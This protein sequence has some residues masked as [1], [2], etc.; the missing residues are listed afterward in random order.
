MAKEPVIHPDSACPHPLASPRGQEVKRGSVGALTAVLT[1]PSLL[2]WP[3]REGRHCPRPPGA[4]P[5]VTPQ[6]CRWRSTNKGS[7]VGWGR[8]PQ[9][10]WVGC[11]GNEACI[12]KTEGGAA[13]GSGPA[14]G[15]WGAGGPPLPALA[16]RL[17]GILA[18]GPLGSFRENAAGREE[19][20]SFRPRSPASWVVPGPGQAP[21]RPAVPG[22]PGWARRPL[23]GSRGVKRSR[24]VVCS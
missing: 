11:P 10:G 5:T 17:P 22:N 4:G 7:A 21:P 9:D 19:G 13:A 20:Q 2:H 23:L 6:L 18:P 15:T 14:R 12:L 3:K 24:W 8:G 16:Q 1:P